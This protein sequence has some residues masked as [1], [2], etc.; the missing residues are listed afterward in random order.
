[1]DDKHTALYS[2]YERAS[3]EGVSVLHDGDRNISP[4]VWEDYISSV[5]D[6]S[7]REVIEL[8]RT[9]TD[10]IPWS[11][12]VHQL[13]ISFHMY[14]RDFNDTPF[15]VFLNTEKFGSENMLLIC[16]WEEL[17][18]SN[19]RGFCMLGDNLNEDDHILIIDDAVYSGNHIANIITDVCF[20]GPCPYFHVVAPY[21]SSH[22]KSLI[23]DASKK[24]V[25]FSNTVNMAPIYS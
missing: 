4:E 8:V 23:R 25:H 5:D 17:K 16:L 3:K 24:E 10:Y 7:Y 11:E 15:L 18:K 1:M 9:Y 22:G 6:E 13:R 19:F 20:T 2:A 14:L 12:L 21:M